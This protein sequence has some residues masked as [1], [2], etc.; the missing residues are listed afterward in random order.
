[1]NLLCQAL[2]ARPKQISNACQYLKF[3][4]VYVSVSTLYM[5]SS[6]TPCLYFPGAVCV[7]EA[8]LLAAVLVANEGAPHLARDHVDL[9]PVE[10]GERSH[11]A[12]GSTPS[13]ARLFEVSTP[14]L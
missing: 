3:P 2:Y 1:M 11:H 9:I 8:V 4:L 12:R 7:V 5:I 10:R 14:C 13:P 6:G